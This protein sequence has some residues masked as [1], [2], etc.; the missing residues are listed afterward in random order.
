MP[1]NSFFKQLSPKNPLIFGTLL[2]TFSGF[3]TK[4]I[5]FF[6]KIF[7]SRIF[8]EEALG[9]IG[10]I[11]PVMIL[12]HSVCI[13]GL[14]NAITRCV[15][16]AKHSKNPVKEYSYLFTGILISVTLSVICSVIVYY[17]SYEISTLFLHEPRC[18][19][20]LKIAA[21]AFPLSSVHACIDGFFFARKMTGFPAFSMLLE[22]FVRVGSV[23]FIYLITLQ[24]GSEL[25]LAA[26]SLGIFAGECTS[27]L[28]SCLFICLYSYSKHRFLFPS[29]LFSFSIGTDLIKLALPI[30]LN[31]ICV[32]ILSSFETTQLPHKLTDYGM[33][34]SQ[35]LSVYGIFSGMAFPLIMFPCALT[36]S[37]SSLLL[38]TIA[39][40][41][42]RHDTKKIKLL[43][44]GT[45]LFSFSLG[46]GCTIFFYIFANIIGAYIFQSNLAACQIRALSFICPFLYSSGMLSSLLN[47]LGKTGFTFMFSMLSLGIR[48]IF[49]FFFIPV[50][51]FKGYMYGILCSQICL[52]LLNILALRRYIIYN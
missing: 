47:G 26:A 33:S 41:Q 8:N 29:A 18:C 7:L 27:A 51:G 12:V 22:Q 17:F 21:L 32:S 19:P 28:L 25:S 16:A 3:L 46:L 50:L 45:I 48:L 40:A 11:S 5:G 10:L 35:A 44:L 24:R 6:Y 2:L 9:I 4:I 37:A 52:D 30:S 39:E 23:Y 36:G 13:C 1:L 20:L 38:P 15:S 49:V 14:Q 42:A 31:R 43:I 34:A